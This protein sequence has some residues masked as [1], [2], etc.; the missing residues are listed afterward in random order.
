MVCALC[1]KNQ[2][3]G[4]LELTP[5]LKWREDTEE[6]PCTPLT[7]VHTIQFEYTHRQNNVKTENTLLSPK[8][9]GESGLAVVSDGVCVCVC[10]RWVLGVGR[11]AKKLRS[12][13]RAFKVNFYYRYGSACRVA[14]AT[15]FGLIPLQKLTQIINSDE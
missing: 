14:I 8:I 4:G 13:F 12:G 7:R 2:K 11:L 1:T 9:N 3:K 15:L 5:T 6:L 10:G